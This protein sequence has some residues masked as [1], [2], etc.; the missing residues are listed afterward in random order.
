M[1]NELIDINKDIHCTP[2]EFWYVLMFCD[3]FSLRSGVDSDDLKS[4]KEHYAIIKN[5]NK[6]QKIF[7]DK[8]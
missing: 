1:N 3:G 7:I 4:G 5:G 8:K 6:Y 2:Y